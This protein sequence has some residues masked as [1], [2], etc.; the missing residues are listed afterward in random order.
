MNA[1]KKLSFMG[2]RMLSEKER[3][4][5]ICSILPAGEVN[6]DFSMFSHEQYSVF[7]NKFGIDDFYHGKKP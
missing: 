1:I 4:E 2:G 5:M 3:L 7:F 6:K